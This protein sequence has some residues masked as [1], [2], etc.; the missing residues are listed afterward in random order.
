M[1]GE[2]NVGHPCSHTQIRQPRVIIGATPQRPMELAL[3]FLDRHVVD[4]REPA[5]HQAIRTEFPVLVSIGAEPVAGVV[6]PLIG[7]AHGNTIVG[8]GPQLLDQPVLKL[9]VPLAGQE[10]PG[11]LAAM[12]ELGA[13][14]PLGVQ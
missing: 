2:A 13:V 6:M 11:F 4:A 7:V 12:G 9:L 1:E 14:A 10:L 8:E 5:L 3:A